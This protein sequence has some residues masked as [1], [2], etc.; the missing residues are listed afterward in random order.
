MNKKIVFCTSLDESMAPTIE[1]GDVLVVDTEITYYQ[2]GGIYCL[3]LGGAK[4]FRRITGWDD[5]K[6]ISCD[7]RTFPPEIA[8]EETINDMIFG[9]VSHVIKQVD[10]ASKI[11]L[12]E[13]AFAVAGGGLEG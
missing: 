10:F 13:D 12:T 1:L 6:I 9:K 3:S 4:H 7:N 11:N 8:E 5:S 2:G